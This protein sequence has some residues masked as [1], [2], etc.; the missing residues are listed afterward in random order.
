MSSEKNLPAE[1]YEA[2]E[3]QE[4]RNRQVYITEPDYKEAVLSLLEATRFGTAVSSAAAQV[5]LSLYHG[6]RFHV[7]LTDFCLFDSLLLDAALKAIRGRVIVSMEPH[8]LIENGTEIFADLAQ[9]W[10]CLDVSNRYPH[11]R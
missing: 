4:F 8:E 5:L 9:E 3:E 2:L 11:H 10:S 6:G 1:F 7:D